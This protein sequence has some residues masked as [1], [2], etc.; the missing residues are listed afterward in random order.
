MELQTIHAAVCAEHPV[1]N[2]KTLEFFITKFTFKES[3]INHP[4]NKQILCFLEVPVLEI[5]KSAKT[6]S[7]EW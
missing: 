2:E 6:V 3:K 7:T 5:C 4:L 1:R